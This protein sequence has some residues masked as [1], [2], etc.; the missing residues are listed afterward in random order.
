[1]RL[2]RNLLYRLSTLEVALGLAIISALCAVVIATNNA[3]GLR[4]RALGYLRTRLSVP[5]EAESLR[6]E[7]VE[8]DRL[9]FA[10][11]DEILPERTLID[12]F[13]NLVGANVTTRDEVR[14]VNRCIEFFKEESN[15]YAI[16]EL[17][18]ASADFAESLAALNSFTGTHFFTWPR[19]STDRFALYPD[20]NIDRGGKGDS[21]EMEMY[22]MRSR[23]LSDL[24]FETERAYKAYRAKVK[25][26][27]LR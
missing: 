3:F 6:Q 12:M 9:V 17:K 19:D 2:S 8:H 25:E 21:G 10:R 24:A 16:P 18:N 1:M 22:G 13:D 4:D 5:T 11:A 7:R 23:E 20:L 15:Q 27:L 14:Q 26:V